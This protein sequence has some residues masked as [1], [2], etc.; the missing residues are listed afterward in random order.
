MGLAV[1]SCLILCFFVLVLTAAQSVE[2]F[3]KPGKFVFKLIGIP[4]LAV[5]VNSPCDYNT[6][7][8]GLIA[9]VRQTFTIR[10]G[11]K[12]SRGTTNIFF[13]GDHTKVGC[14]NING[15]SCPSGAEKLGE[16][17]VYNSKTVRDQTFHADFSAGN[18]KIL[19]RGNYRVVRETLVAWH[20]ETTSINRCVALPTAYQALRTQL[21][22]RS[23]KREVRPDM[24]PNAGKPTTDIDVATPQFGHD[25]GAVISTVA[26]TDGRAETWSEGCNQDDQTRTET[27]VN[28]NADDG[29]QRSN[30][31][32]P[33]RDRRVTAVTL[34]LTLSR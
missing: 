6:T 32:P 13:M 1:H 20:T 25:G 19:G 3:E 26:S 16:L 2:R 11:T 15:S 28:T 23:S 17:Y 29:H 4:F 9:D 18:A 5:S 33:T 31:P 7:V 30:A 27:K 22:E 34:P 10:A 12:I 14:I 8:C 21:N 24:N